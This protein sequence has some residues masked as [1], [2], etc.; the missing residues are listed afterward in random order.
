M[1]DRICCVECKKPIMIMSAY[2]V[3]AVGTDKVVQVTNFG[4][5]NADCGKFNVITDRTETPFDVM[6]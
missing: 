5:L 4:C 2:P 3:S 1:S 6:E